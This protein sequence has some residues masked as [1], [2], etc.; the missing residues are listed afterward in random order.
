MLFVLQN[1]DSPGLIWKIFRNKELPARHDRNYGISSIAAHPC[2]KRKD[3]G[4][5]VSLWEWKNQRL[6]GGP[7]ALV[8]NFALACLAPISQP[9]KKPQADTECCHC[10]SDQ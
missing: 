5:L 6:E 1:L 9:V 8:P 7:P 10:G 4:T 2:R 3:G